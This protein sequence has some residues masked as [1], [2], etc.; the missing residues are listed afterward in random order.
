MATQQATDEKRQ[1]TDT[2]KA[3][4]ASPRGT[5]PGQTGAQE[6]SLRKQ[7]PESSASPGEGPLTQK[8]RAHTLGGM[9]QLHEESARTTATSAGRQGKSD[10]DAR[11]R[12]QEHRVQ[13]RWGGTPQAPQAPPRGPSL[14]E[15]LYKE[16]GEL[17]ALAY[18]HS[19][20]E[21]QICFEGDCEGRTG[22]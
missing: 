12:F 8:A 6:Q 20:E 1:K 9:E 5:D 3:A 4:P 2:T 10:E 14:K 17:E 19:V 13:K 18:G 15:E 7:L 16:F 21:S 22:F 11:V